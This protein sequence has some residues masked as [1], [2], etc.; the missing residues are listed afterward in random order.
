MAEL[1]QLIVEEEEVVVVVLSGLAVPSL[2]IHTAAQVP[3]THEN[4]VRISLN[5]LYILSRSLGFFLLAGADSLRL[6]QDVCG[7]F[8]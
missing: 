1:L 7:G 5:P 3:H 4:T 8:I 2:Q 6:H